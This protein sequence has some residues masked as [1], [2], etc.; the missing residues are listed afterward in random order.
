MPQNRTPDHHE[1]NGAVSAPIAGSSS[2]DIVREAAV[3]G[4]F[5]FD[6]QWDMVS[7]PSDLDPG[8]LND[9]F[10]TGDE[11]FLTGKPGA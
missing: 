1:R 7:T 8:Y 5:T 10:V 11:K 2:V 6:V 3:S 4:T 9:Y